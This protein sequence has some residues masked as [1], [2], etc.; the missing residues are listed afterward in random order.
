MI[1]ALK[2]EFKEISKSL[3]KSYCFI[4]QKTLADELMRLKPSELWIT[5]GNDT[6]QK[7]R[8]IR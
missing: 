3:F 1:R 7:M 5:Q 8:K 2:H 6:S 4:L